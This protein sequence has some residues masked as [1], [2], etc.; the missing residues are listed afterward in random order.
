MVV[1]RIVASF[2]A[3]FH[4]CMSPVGEIRRAVGLESS[5]SNGP[6]GFLESISSFRYGI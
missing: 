6:L 2:T 5:I 1:S 4:C 3:F